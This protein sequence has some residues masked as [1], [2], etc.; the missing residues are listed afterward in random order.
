MKK[1][2]QVVESVSR[3]VRVAS[4]NCVKKDRRVGEYSFRASIKTKERLLVRRARM[5]VSVAENAKKS[6]NLERLKWRII[7]LTLTSTYAACAVSVWLLVLPMQYGKLTFH[8]EKL[9]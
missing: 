8:P 3:R 5:R 2:V 6:A 7:S 9:M 4:L 1:N